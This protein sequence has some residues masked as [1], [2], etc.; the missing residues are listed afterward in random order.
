MEPRTEHDVQ[1][2]QNRNGLT[3][4]VVGRDC[5]AALDEGY[6]YFL[7]L[8]KWRGPGP[9]KFGLIHHQVTNLFRG[10]SKLLSLNLRK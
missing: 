7:L 9:D 2:K 3:S 5:A 1:T 8:E 10:W 4:D 6:R